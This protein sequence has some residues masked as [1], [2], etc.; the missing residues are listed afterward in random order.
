MEP[1]MEQS[2]PGM[3]SHFLNFYAR[4][5][6]FSN[7]FFDF[8]FK[9]YGL[10]VFLCLRQAAS[11]YASLRHTAWQRHSRHRTFLPRGE[12]GKAPTLLTHTVTVTHNTNALQ[13]C[14]VWFRTSRSFSFSFL[15]SA[16]KLLAFIRI[17]TIL[18]S[19]LYLPPSRCL[20]LTRVLVF[21]TTDF[22]FMFCSIF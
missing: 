10:R 17:S 9:V 5:A 19:C 1:W 16:L 3:N 21:V 11:R 13:V 12:Q 7:F 20:W 22:C 15:C 8:C 18:H 4:N 2:E 14:L 6:K